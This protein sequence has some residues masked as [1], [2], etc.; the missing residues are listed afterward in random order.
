MSK[1]DPML[2]EEEYTNKILKMEKE[3]WDREQIHMEVIE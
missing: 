1:Y 3:R 2:V